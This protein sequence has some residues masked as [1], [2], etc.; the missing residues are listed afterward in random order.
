M[1]TS[2]PS[3]PLTTPV[4][5]LRARERSQGVQSWVLLAD[6]EDNEFCVLRSIAP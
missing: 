4:Q 5:Q 1:A 6:P 2:E 3:T